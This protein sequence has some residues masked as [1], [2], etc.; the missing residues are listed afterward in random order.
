MGIRVLHI[1]GASQYGGG[2]SVIFSLCRMAREKGIEPFVL[3]SDP[4][5]QQEC[6]RRGITVIAFAGIERAI[7]PWKDFHDGRRLATYLAQE[8]FEI[9]H[10]HT[11]KGGMIGRYAAS[12]AK[13]PAVFHTVHGFAFHA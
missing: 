1:V 12:R 10:T 8:R 3:T 5:G 4:V 6:K 7:R 9:V 11:S 13:V 2:F